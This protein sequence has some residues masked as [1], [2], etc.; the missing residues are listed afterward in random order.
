MAV[1]VRPCLLWRPRD[2]SPPDAVAAAAAAALPAHAHVV[3]VFLGR[4]SFGQA[5]RVWAAR[6]CVGSLPGRSL[7]AGPHEE[8]RRA[9]PRREAARAR[10]GH[11]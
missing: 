4:A 9:G 7:L 10:G 3:F 6:R 8:L 2:A 11:G 1:R 5:A